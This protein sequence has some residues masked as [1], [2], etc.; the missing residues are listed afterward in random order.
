MNKLDKSNLSNL[1]VQMAAELL[2]FKLFWIQEKKD[3]LEA[4]LSSSDGMKF[5]TYYRQF[6]EGVLALANK[7]ID[8]A[9][10][11]FNSISIQNPFFEQGTIFIAEFFTDHGNED[12][13]YDILLNG[14]KINPYSLNLNKAY[15]KI[16]LQQGLDQYAIDAISEFEKIMT[17]EAANQLMRYY[18]ELQN[19]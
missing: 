11:H 2:Q 16:C 4:M 7:N 1:D 12:K 9:A 8:L 14:I 6:G 18:N 15:I 3:Q 13:A 10:K 19:D 17:N 5:P